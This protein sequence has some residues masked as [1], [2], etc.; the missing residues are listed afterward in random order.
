MTTHRNVHRSFMLSLTGLFALL[1]VGCSGPREMTPP[2][3]DPPPDVVALFDGGVVTMEEFETQ[4][5]RSVGGREAAAD[6]S[7]S[8]YQD[9]LSR[10]LDFRLKVQAARDAG[11]DRDSS[12]Q[13][14]I[15]RYRN[16]LARPYLLEQRVTEPLLRDLYEK[17]KEVVDASHILIRVSPNASP[18]DTLE[19][20]NRI[21]A[22]RDSAL[23]G[24]DFG[25]LAFRHSEDPSAQGNGLGARGRLGYFSGGR[26][27]KAFE[28]VA[29]KTPVG[30]VSE[31][32]RSPYGY[33]LVYVHDHKP[34][35]NDIRIAHIMIRIKGNTAADTMAALA[36]I[37]T[38]RALLAEGRDFAEVAK[39]Y[40]EDMGS[41]RAGGDL[42]F[43]SYDSRLI[44]PL[45]STAFALEH[46]GDLSEPIL[47]RFG[48][49]I[50][51]LEEIRE[52]RSYEESKED[53]KAAL[54]RLP[55]STEYMKKFAE[56]I[57]KREG[58]ALDTTLVY[59]VF[60]TTSTDSVFVVFSRGGLPDSLLALEFASIGDSTY[61]IGELIAFTQKNTVTRQQDTRKMILQ[62]INTFLDD[63]AVDLEVSALEERDPDFR[64]TMDE[65]RNGLLL[66]RLMEDSVWTA[67]AQD[68]AALRTYYEAH[69]EKYR[70]PD[71]TRII[72][73]Y[74]DSDSLLNAMA[75]QLD[76][77]RSVED[78]AGSTLFDPDHKVRIDTTLVAGATNSVFDQALNLEPGAHTQVMPYTKGYILMVN[79]GIEPA[80]PK[81]FEE[82]QAEVINDYQQVLEDRLL[83][84]LRRRYHA[85]LFPERLTRAFQNEPSDRASSTSSTQ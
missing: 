79:D 19:A 72:A 55:R 58:D 9:F 35:P 65:F 82:A 80:R 1:L 63:R 29:F 8:E 59:S 27:V 46:V 32:F 74:A 34:K 69:A 85:R 5:A 68:S 4:Y 23:Q 52:P 75:E 31:I 22:L 21:A 76:A 45:K 41:A 70:F 84:R 78:L 38:V 20:Y 25:D 28:D 42:G 50:I 60:D 43:I 48:Y 16:Q 24:V 83:A 33:H 56:Q 13:A 66:F 17:K 36:R 62:G 7:L 39:E 81:T 30:Q 44:E 37:D 3:N 53:L 71:R 77:G 47:S 73:F 61:T 57:R 6:D 51:K 11:L 14:E 12:L 10:Y 67:A 15:A 26:M 49:H 40:S 64:A 2:S 18:E 54:A